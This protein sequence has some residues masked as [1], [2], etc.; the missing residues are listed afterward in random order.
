[1]V[2][3]DINQANTWERKSVTIDFASGTSA[4]TWGTTNSY[5]V[6]LQWF[7]GANANRIGDT[8]LNSWA[9]WSAYE[10]M[11]SSATNW[12]TNANAT[13][14]LT[15]VQ[16]E[17]GDKATPFEHRS[18][19]EELALCERYFQCWRGTSTSFQVIGFGNGYTS[20]S[21]FPQIQTKRQMRVAPHTLTGSYCYLN[22]VT[23]SYV[24]TSATIEMSGPDGVRL[25][26]I[27]PGGGV[28]YRG[29]GFT[30]NNNTTSFFA[31]SAEL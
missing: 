21:I 27:I 6:L 2:E 4:G 3:Y 1:V 30:T 16:L 10:V 24:N 7:L 13:F 5:G 23:T 22:D 29:Y 18:Y 25:N 14:Y 9:N 20:T 31:L 8:Y 19:G 28:Q 15:G 17:I 11:S 12:G 26:A